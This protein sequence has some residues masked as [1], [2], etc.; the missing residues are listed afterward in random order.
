M[1]RYKP[2]EDFRFI[3]QPVLVP[4]IF[5]TDENGDRCTVEPDLD[6]MFVLAVPPSDQLN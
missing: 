4:L 3:D 1:N 6:E 5:W 2:H